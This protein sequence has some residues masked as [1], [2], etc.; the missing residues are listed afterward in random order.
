MGRLVEIRRDRGT[1]DEAVAILGVSDRTV[2]D[3]ALRGEP[4]GAAKIGRRWTFDLA[5]YA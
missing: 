2:R 5:R 3:L 1:I 4:P